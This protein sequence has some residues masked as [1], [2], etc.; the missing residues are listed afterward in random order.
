MAQA[1]SQ[2]AVHDDWIG[3]AFFLP[4][5]KMANGTGTPG[6]K[7]LL[8]ILGKIRADKALT[9]SVHWGD[10]N[11]I[12]DGVLTRAPEQMM[13]YAAKYRV[14]GDRMNETLA[15]MINTVGEY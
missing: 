15:D 8:E 4:A 10:S 7:S 12:R 5:E 6:Q 2:A 3:R 1:L 11:K 9:E 14:T 13:S